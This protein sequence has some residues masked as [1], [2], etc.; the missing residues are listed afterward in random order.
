MVDAYSVVEKARTKLICSWHNFT[1]T[2]SASELEA[3]LGQQIASGAHIGKIVTMAEDS[4]D[5]LRVLNLPPLAA[6]HGFPLI[7]F[8][9]GEAGMISRAATL[10]L[11]GYMTYAAPDSG[12]GSAP[13]QLP[14]SAMRA[15]LAS[16]N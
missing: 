14:V 5:V 2:P 8:C 9:M 12:K 6:E 13:G 10:F 3:I 15:M 11:G 7:A 16:L 4:R 1:L